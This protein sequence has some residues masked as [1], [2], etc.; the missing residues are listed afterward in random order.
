MNSQPTLRFLQRAAGMACDLVS[1]LVYPMIY[2]GENG[3]AS[4]GTE[5]TIMIVRSTLYL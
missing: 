3:K 4:H 5:D 2:L 1:Q